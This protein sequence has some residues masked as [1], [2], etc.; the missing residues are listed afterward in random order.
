MSDQATPPNDSPQEM[1]TKLSPS[2]S[3]TTIAKKHLVLNEMSIG[4]VKKFGIEI[5]GAI[6]KIKTLTDTEDVSEL[7]IDMLLSEWGEQLFEVIAHLF[8][9]LFSYRNDEYEPVT[10][11]WVEDNLSI[12]EMQ[13]IIVEVADQNGMGWLIPFFK[14]SGMDALRKFTLG[15]S[16]TPQDLK[17][18]A[19]PNGSPTPTS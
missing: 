14:S 17:N 13:E 10:A 2:A 8:N 5:V 6:E 3:S 7:T 15:L 18:D 16:K 19:T 1:W 11:E 9:F 4:R 12:R